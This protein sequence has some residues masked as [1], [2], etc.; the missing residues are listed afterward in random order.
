MQQLVGLT[1]ERRPRRPKEASLV[2]HDTNAAAGCSDAGQ[3]TAQRDIVTGVVPRDT[4]ITRPVV[5]GAD[6]VRY[7]IG[8]MS[9]GC[10]HKKLLTVPGCITDCHR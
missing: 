3:H 9:S 2:W 10:C 5:I 4:A 8:Q 1:V 7:K 6:G